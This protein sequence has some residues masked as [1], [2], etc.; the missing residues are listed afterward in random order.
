MG[1]NYIYCG[2]INDNS[3][4]CSSGNILGSVMSNIA[5]GVYESGNKDVA[6]DP[7]RCRADALGNSSCK[8]SSSYS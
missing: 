8:A 6:N 7:T 5:P 3:P 4:G 2:K 1:N